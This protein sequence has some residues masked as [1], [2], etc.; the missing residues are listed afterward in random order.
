MLSFL[1]SAV[2]RGVNGVYYLGGSGQAALSYPDVTPDP[3]LGQAHMVFQV[4]DGTS[5]LLG[6]APYGDLSVF[7]TPPWARRRSA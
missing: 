2:Y 1:R 6:P 3:S 7:R 5:R 4:Q